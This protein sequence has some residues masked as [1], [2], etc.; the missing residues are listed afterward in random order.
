MRKAH[1][2]VGSLSDAR[3]GIRSFANSGE[4]IDIRSALAN[5]RNT[6]PAQFTLYFDGQFW[7]GVYETSTGCKLQAT[8]V[9]FGPEPN[10]AEL[11]EWILNN[12]SSLIKTAKAQE[13][14]PG[15]IEAATKGNPKRL[16]RAINKQRQNDGI[17]SKAEQ[18]LKLN[19]E[20][21]KAN[22]KIRHREKKKQQEQQKF[23]RNRL[24][25]I[26]K[27]KGK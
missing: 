9:V 1:S 16:Q 15:K 26:Q 19:F 21:S 27:R 23:D 2:S 13:P 14:I 4:S 22:K 10:N 18:A 7:R 20:L 3:A 8:E 25:R 12:G 6:M 17:S 5:L 24:K 11:Y